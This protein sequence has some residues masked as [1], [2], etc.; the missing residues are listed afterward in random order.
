M[1]NGNRGLTVIAQCTDQ[2]REKEMRAEDLYMASD[3]FEAQR[4]YAEAYADRWYILSGKYGLIRPWKRIKPY[5]MHI[6]DQTSEVWQEQVH[7]RINTIVKSGDKVEIIAGKE[8]YGKRIEWALEEHD[9]EYEYPFSGLGIG[10]RTN[11]MKMEARK[12]ENKGLDAYA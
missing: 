3:L 6:S 4:R 10:E 2:K 12:V 5:D 11:A 1:E 8:D 9:V 7:D